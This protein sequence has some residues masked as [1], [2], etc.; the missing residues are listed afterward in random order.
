MQP[1]SAAAYTAHEL[2]LINKYGMHRDDDG[3]FR[4]MYSRAA[5]LEDLYT[6]ERVAC[7]GIDKGVY[8]GPNGL[9]ELAADMRHVTCRAWRARSRLTWATGATRMCSGF[10]AAASSRTS[11]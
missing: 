9:R 7:E 11:R 5:K 10:A 4:Q 1:P 2:R 6:L 8:A 3:A